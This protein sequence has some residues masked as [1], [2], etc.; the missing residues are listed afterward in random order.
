MT[1]GDKFRAA[2][3]RVIAK[4]CKE[5]GYSTLFS[6]VESTSDYDTTT[7][8]VAPVYVEYTMYVALDQ[9]QI[10]AIILGNRHV[11]MDPGYTRDS[12]IA[13]IAGLDTPVA[14]KAGDLIRPAGDTK[15][16]RVAD[17]ALDM[18]N[19]LYT[20]MVSRKPE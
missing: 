18:Y 8:V 12:Q 11:E 4:F 5:N 16:Y 6:L 1:L 7:G 9:L 19:A 13:Y 3:S 2:A 20:C 15:R 10:G 17:T 14:I